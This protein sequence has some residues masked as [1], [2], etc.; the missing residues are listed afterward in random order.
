[1]ADP[2][3][4]SVAPEDGTTITPARYGEG[5]PIVLAGGAFD[6]PA[7]GLPKLPGASFKVIH[8][9]RTASTIESCAER[10]PP[11]PC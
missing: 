7:A 3:T 1:M 4:R 11:P 9:S 10:Q 8:V 6:P 2:A 5:P